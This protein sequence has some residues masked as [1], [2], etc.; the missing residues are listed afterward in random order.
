MICKKKYLPRAIKERTFY[1]NLYSTRN[2]HPNNSD[3]GAFFNNNL[4]TPLNED[5]SKKC[6]GM[7]S[8]QECYLWRQLLDKMFI[9]SCRIIMS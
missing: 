3:F 5:Q 4:L 9:S 8:E 2:V 7:L 1:K 6:E